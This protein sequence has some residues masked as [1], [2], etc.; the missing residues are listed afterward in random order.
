MGFFCYSLSFS[1]D[2]GLESAYLNDIYLFFISMSLGGQI[3]V[4]SFVH[5]S[6]GQFSYCEVLDVLCITIVPFSDLFC[7]GI[8]LCD[9]FCLPC[10]FS[11]G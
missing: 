8:L 9:L 7:R 2:N 1:H 3:T 6:T 4:L 5:F 11:R 10:I